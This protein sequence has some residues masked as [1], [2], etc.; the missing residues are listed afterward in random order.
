[1]PAMFDRDESPMVNQSIISQSVSQWLP[2][3][4]ESTGSQAEPM[5]LVLVTHT[6]SLKFAHSFIHSLDLLCCWPFAFSPRARSLPRSHRAPAA[7]LAEVKSD[8]AW[9]LGYIL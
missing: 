1:M 5:V 7:N 3:F 2:P 4:S 6:K 8:Q 9:Y